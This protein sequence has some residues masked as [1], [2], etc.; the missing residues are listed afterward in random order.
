MRIGIDIDGVLTDFEQWQLDYGSKF[1]LETYHKEIVCNNAYETRTIFDA[2]KEQDDAFWM[3][4]FKD[5]AQH[6][7][8]RPFASEVIR[9]LHQ[10]GNEIIMITARGDHASHSSTV[11]SL[12]EN[13]QVTVDWL[14]HNQIEYDKIIFQANDKLE[15]CKNE[16]ID[17]MI[18]DK[19]QNIVAISS[20]IP[21][22]C[23]H[24]RYN[25]NCKGKNIIRCYS[26]Y[27]INAKIH[28]FINMI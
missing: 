28:S 7:P 21:V 9:N 17:V 19:P 14:H 3:K 8:V 6:I 26:W 2:S 15:I 25:T 20:Q 12:E 5:Y 1:Y 10:A 4:C 16:K 22:I 23:Y 24:A 13:K 27:D 18:D 11:M